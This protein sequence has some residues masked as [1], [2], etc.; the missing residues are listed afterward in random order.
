M[1]DFVSDLEMFNYF[2]SWN[3]KVSEY[4]LDDDFEIIDN[5]IKENF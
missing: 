4:F 5:E 3:N 1:S 2:L